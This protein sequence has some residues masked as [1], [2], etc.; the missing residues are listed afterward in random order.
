MSASC[1]ASINY[2]WKCIQFDAPG[3]FPAILVDLTQINFA[4]IFSAKV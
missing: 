2:G 3:I 1:Q 4:G